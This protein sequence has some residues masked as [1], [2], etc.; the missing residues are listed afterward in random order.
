[1]TNEITENDIHFETE[2]NIILE[3]MENDFYSN[4]LKS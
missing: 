4:T 3:S 1:M 2:C